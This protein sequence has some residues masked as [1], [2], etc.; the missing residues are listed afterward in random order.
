[1]FSDLG[2]LAV[3]ERNGYKKA[4]RRTEGFKKFWV[5][6]KRI[7]LSVCEVDFEVN[8]VCVKVCDT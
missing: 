2:G 4:I 1:M 3:S 5:W 6:E 8:K 7:R